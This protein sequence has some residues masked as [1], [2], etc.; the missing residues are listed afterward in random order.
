MQE[1]ITVNARLIGLI[2]YCAVA[3]LQNPEPRP[4]R[5]SEGKR[6]PSSCRSLG[7]NEQLGTYATS[8]RGKFT[9]GFLTSVLK[10]LSAI[11]E[12][13]TD[14]RYPLPFLSV[15]HSTSLDSGSLGV[16][17]DR[18]LVANALVS[19]RRSG[20]VR[21]EQEW[22]IIGS[23][24]VAVLRRLSN[25]YST[26]HLVLSRCQDSN[27]VLNDHMAGLTCH[28]TGVELIAREARLESKERALVEKRHE[29]ARRQD[30]IKSIEKALHARERMIQ[31]REATLEAKIRR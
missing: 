6:V 10:W 29:L 11:V 21:E 31:A 13:Y 16:S 19:T 26:D 23:S 22:P 28:C 14:D 12:K 8:H 4:P 5:R 17:H 2:T 30:T 7:P 3:A 1:Y 15:A 27:R 18:W 20:K 24:R 25:L 9:S